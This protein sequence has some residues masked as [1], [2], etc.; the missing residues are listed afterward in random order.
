MD[1]LLI[2]AIAGFV[3]VGAVSI[4]L[5]RHGRGLGGAGIRADQERR[6]AAAALEAEDLAQLLTATNARR[7]A[8]GLPE[9]T[10]RDVV[11]DYER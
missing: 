6:R 9:R 10:L 5:G 1:A 8:R 3:T 2:V 4:R 11:R 7:R